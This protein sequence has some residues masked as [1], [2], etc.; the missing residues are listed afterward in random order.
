MACAV[1]HPGARADLHRASHPRLAALRQLLRRVRPGPRRP[2][3]GGRQ[4]QPLTVAGGAGTLA[5]TPQRWT[6]RSLKRPIALSIRRRRVSAV[7]ASSM[8]STYHCFWLKLR[9]SKKSFAAGAPASG[10][11]IVGYNDLARLGVELDRHLHAI[12]RDHACRGTVLG[13]DADQVA[14]PAVADGRAVG[15]L[16]ERDADRRALACVERGGRLPGHPEAGGRLAG[17]LERDAQPG[18]VGGV[19]RGGGG[20]HGGA[21]W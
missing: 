4:P 19:R 6:R 5:A 21:L 9:L 17:P 10:R 13:A 15:V 18:G 14:S 8:P 11:E 3:R 7:F 12:A 16:A 1:L 2:Q 20:G